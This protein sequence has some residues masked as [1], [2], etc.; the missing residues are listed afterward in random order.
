M[1]EVHNITFSIIIPTY[2]SSF[3]LETCLS[4]VV[5]QDYPKGNIEI[6]VS[7]GGSKDNTL[8]IAK[9]F[10]CRILNNKERLAE[11][12]VNLG[13]KNASNDVSIILAVDNILED[14]DFLKKIS[15][16]F[17]KSDIFAVF[18]N[19]L[20]TDEDS[21][22]TK[23]WNYFTDP[24]NHFVYGNAANNRTFARV[25]DVLETG[26]NYV[27]YKFDK[28]D[29]P[30]LAFAQ[31]FALRNS[32]VRPQGTEGDDLL[33][34]IG[35]IEGGKKFAHVL[36]T[37]VVHHCVKDLKHYIKKQRWAID[38]FLLKKEY[39]VGS[40]V[41]KMS[42]KRKIKIYIWPFY[43]VSFFLPLLRSLYGVIRDRTFIWLYSPILNF[44]TV[45]ILVLE[46]F[47]VKIWKR[48]NI[49]SRQ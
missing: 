30:M 44:V 35:L 16:P 33:P 22:I 27:V 47:R 7:D 5:K 4:A 9:K 34:I 28:R 45:W 40:R 24:F 21:W 26:D 20:S 18:V 42:I 13:I 3:W 19:H 41:V 31:G 37:G 1:S 2:N 11:P 49:I 43:A 15:I 36:N 39:G 14:R 25:Y 8:E 32:Y 6:I 29:Y 12:G 46:V 17:L 48:T 38:N 10:N 23:Y